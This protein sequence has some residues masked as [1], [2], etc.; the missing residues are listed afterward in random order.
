MDVWCLCL[1]RSSCP[2]HSDLCSLCVSMYVHSFP[3]RTVSLR[4][5]GKCRNIASSSQI[6]CH[7]S[8][9]ANRLTPAWCNLDK[10]ASGWMPRGNGAFHRPRDARFD[11]QGNISDVVRTC[12]LPTAFRLVALASTAPWHGLWRN[13]SLYASA[14]CP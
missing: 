14:A 3:A 6:F 12:H 11:A 9:G 4:V 2:Y 10:K 5:P 1:F 8:M 7:R 13:V